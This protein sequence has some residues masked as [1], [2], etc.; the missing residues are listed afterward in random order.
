MDQIKLSLNVKFELTAPLMGCF[1][2]LHLDTDTALCC[3]GRFEVLESEL[4][5]SLN[6]SLQLKEDKL[7]ALEARLR[8]SSSLNQQLRQELRSVSCSPHLCTLAPVHA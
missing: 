8:E 3:S 2:H 1:P 5:S 6:K 7:A 4:V